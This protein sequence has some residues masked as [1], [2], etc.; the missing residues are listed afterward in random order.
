MS[1]YIGGRGGGRER[2]EIKISVRHQSSGTSLIM[3][4]A[5]VMFQ[6]KV[7]FDSYSLQNQLGWVGWAFFVW[8]VWFLTT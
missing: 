5:K 2:W 6:L 8:L 1:V 3:T 7:A 4:N